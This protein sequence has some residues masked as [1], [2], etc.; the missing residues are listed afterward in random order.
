MFLQE[1][2][3]NPCTK[4]YTNIDVDNYEFKLSLQEYEEIGKI[5]EKMILKDRQQRISLEE[6]KERLGLILDAYEWS[7]QFNPSPCYFYQNLYLYELCREN[8]D[9]EPSS[10]SFMQFL[11]FLCYLSCFLDPSI[12]DFSKLISFPQD[13]PTRVL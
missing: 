8:K 9:Y 6:V 11:Y 1:I 13:T 7:L 5:L 3:L 10:W 2:C 12:L 4:K